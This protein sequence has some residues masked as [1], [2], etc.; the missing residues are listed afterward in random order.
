MTWHN[1]YLDT[2]LRSPEGQSYLRWSGNYDAWRRRHI[3]DDDIP[4]LPPEIVVEASA[5]ED[6]LFFIPKPKPG[7]TL[8]DLAKR[9]V[10]VTGIKTDWDF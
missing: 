1:P 6:S 10:G 5:P 3:L 9:S 8:E 4:A 7:E 2:F